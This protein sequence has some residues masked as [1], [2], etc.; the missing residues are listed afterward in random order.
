VIEELSKSLVRSKLQTFDE[1]SLLFNSLGHYSSAQGAGMKNSS[2]WAR[3]YGTIVKT[4]ITV[5]RKPSSFTAGAELANLLTMFSAGQ[6]PFGTKGGG[7]GCLNQDACSF[8]IVGGL[9]PDR[10]KTVSYEQKRTHHTSA[11]P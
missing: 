10:A 9:Q 5:S 4:C 7:K 8:A 2:N 3:T 11:S 1:L 6:V